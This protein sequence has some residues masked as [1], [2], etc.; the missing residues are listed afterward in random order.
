LGMLFLGIDILQNG[1]ASLTSIFSLQ[2]LG[3][4]SIL[5]LLLLI[6]IGVVMTVVMQSSGAAFIITLSALVAD[7]ITFEQAAA[8]AIGQNVGTTIKAYIASIGGTV[9]AKRTA[10]AHIW[11]NLFT[12]AVALILFP[13]LIPGVIKFGNMIHIY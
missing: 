4:P 12:G 8:L 9:A 2:F 13:W 11:F 3:S 7:T 5:Q 1:M 10:L 6:V